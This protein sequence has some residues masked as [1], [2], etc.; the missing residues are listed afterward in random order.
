MMPDLIIV[1]SPVLRP[2][3][4]SGATVCARGTSAGA[5]VGNGD[6]RQG[7]EDAAVT[8]SGGVTCGCDDGAPGLSDSTT[9]GPPKGESTAASSVVSRCR[10]LVAASL[11]TA[12]RI[13]QTRLTPR[14]RL[15]LAAA[16]RHRDGTAMVSDGTRAR[17]A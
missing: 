15:M 17:P 11:P 12:L 1:H 7:P 3:R 14:R 8:S 6:K 4:R 10:N 2:T 13:E 5:T 9:M 16:T